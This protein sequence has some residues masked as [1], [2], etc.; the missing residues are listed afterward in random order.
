MNYVY[1]DWLVAG[2]SLMQADQNY[3]KVVAVCF[4][5]LQF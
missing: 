1:C 3:L 4:G 2:T 5:V